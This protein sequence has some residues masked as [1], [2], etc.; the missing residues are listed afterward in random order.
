[1]HFP[2]NFWHNMPLP[3]QHTFLHCQKVCFA[4]LQN[5]A[6]MCAKFHFKMPKKCGSTGKPRY[7]GEYV[8]VIRDGRPGGEECLEAADHRG[9]G[10]QRSGKGVKS[11]RGPWPL[12]WGCCDPCLYPS[13]P[14][15][16]GRVWPT[17][18]A[19]ARAA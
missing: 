9:R 19:G 1:M 11:P 6:T 18:R 16:G 3:W 8:G 7:D 17:G 5:T 13:C 10:P 12:G 2:L 4:Q 14:D 15:P